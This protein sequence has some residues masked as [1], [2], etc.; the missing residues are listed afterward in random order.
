MKSPLRVLFPLVTGFGGNW[1]PPPSVVQGLVLR[2]LRVP[3]G[4]FGDLGDFDS[5]GDEFLGVRQKLQAELT[6]WVFSRIRTTGAEPPDL[7]LMRPPKATEAG[8]LMP[9]MRKRP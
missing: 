9:A 1:P 8:E 2:G 6:T 3:L 7:L 5:F 4:D